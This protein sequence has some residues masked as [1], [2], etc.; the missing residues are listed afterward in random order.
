MPDSAV[1]ARPEDVLHFWFEELEPASWWR[2]DEGLDQRIRQRFAALHAAASA[3]E[4]WGWRESAEGRLA[5]VIVLDQ[6]SRNLFREGARAFA[7]DA[8]ALALAQEAVRLGADRALAPTQRSFLYLPYMHSES[9]KIHDQALQLFDQPG[10]ENNLDFERRH[11]DLILRFG[12]YPHRNAVLGRD[13]TVEEQAY[14]A[15]PGA[16]F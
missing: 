1:D 10:L 12:R 8:M 13:S 4:L 9:L 5:E 11:R 3:A 16:G 14:L 7:Q 6:F 15:E 2:K